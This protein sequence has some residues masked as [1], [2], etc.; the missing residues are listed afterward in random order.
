MKKT[1]RSL[2]AV[3]QAA[4]KASTDLLAQTQPQSKAMTPDNSRIT[5][6]MSTI[7]ASWNAYD[8]S[9]QDQYLGIAQQVNTAEKRTGRQ[10]LNGWTM[11]VRICAVRL[12]CSMGLPTEVPTYETVASLPPVLM[13]ATVSPADAAPGDAPSLTLTL[14]SVNYDGM[15]QCFG[16]P[17]LLPK[18]SARNDNKWV[19]LG[20][21][22]GL[23]VTG[24][25]IS[26]L[27]TAKMP[28]PSVGAKVCLSLVPVADSGLR[29][30][31]TIA[32][33]VVTQTGAA[34]TTGKDTPAK[35]ANAKKADA[36]KMA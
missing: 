29:G 32:D 9:V 11:Y 3:T 24:T 13:N 14:H 31:S 10:K 4:Q 27:W 35:K 1:L 33:A 36:L 15:I 17:E 2:R 30:P 21:I 16:Y 12:N 7:A 6:N 25:E 26:G 34:Q 18:Q 22:D 19:S 23:S 8:K 5:G 28:L 20:T